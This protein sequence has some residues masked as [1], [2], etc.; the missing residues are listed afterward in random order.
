MVDDDV[1]RKGPVHWMR[2]ETVV[3]RK[4]RCLKEL[5]LKDEV[6]KSRSSKMDVPSSIGGCGP[7]RTLSIVPE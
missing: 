5:C 1:G 6:T 2:M 3:R 4:E 7:L